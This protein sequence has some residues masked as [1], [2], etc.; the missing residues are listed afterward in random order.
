M[1]TGF[2]SESS[3][4]WLT[5]QQSRRLARVFGGSKEISRSVI[6]TSK[7]LKSA[8]DFLDCFVPAVA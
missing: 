1:I 4:K 8:S 2:Q 7:G 3:T 6:A 5:L